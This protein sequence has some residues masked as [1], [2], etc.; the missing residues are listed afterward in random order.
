MRDRHA[1]SRLYAEAARAIIPGGA[2]AYAKGEDQYPEGMAPVI[3]RGEGCRV[4]D[5]DG[6]EYVEYG[7]GLRSVTLGHNNPEISAAVS[8]TLGL[9]VNFCRPHRLELEAAERL[10]GLLP[11]AEMVK[12][13]VNGSD[14]TNGAIRLSRAHTGRDMV[15]V[16]TD[17]AFFS[18][19]DWFIGGT[20]MHAGIP[21]ATREL[22][23]G[24]RYNELASVE[25][26][27]TEHEGR[28]AALILEAETTEPPAEGFF[29]GLRQLCDRHGV[30][31]VLDEIITGFRWHLRGAQHV[32]GIEPDL[33][34][35]GKGMANGL[36]VSALAGRREIMEL[37]GF[38]SDRDRVFLLSQ[39][40]AAQPWILAAVLA[41]IDLH[42]SE[43]VAA[44]LQRAGARLRSGVEAAVAARGLADHL[45]VIGRDCNLV[46]ATRDVAGERSQ[47]F[48]T[49][50]LQELLDRG[51]LSPSFVVSLAHDDEAIDRT[52]AAVEGA[53]PAYERALE[54]GLE[55]VLRGRPVQP[56]IRPRG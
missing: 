12:F 25:A 10:L 35:F 41:M 56:A 16:C 53:L 13:G 5:V 46:F 26:L 22:T 47:G 44:R 39:T 24:F 6:N 23:V 18:T 14:A 9:G 55:G 43:D 27:L 1:R 50:F 48:R 42:E 51:V 30:V 3:E 31:L 33:S 17:H 32:H 20:A 37:G 21:A 34:T 29:A 4:W 40:Y 45:Q 54:G 49:L 28:I 36:P 52:I 7:I 38:A 8:S 15:A 2:H 19:A 11:T